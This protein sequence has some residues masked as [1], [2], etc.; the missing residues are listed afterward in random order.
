MIPKLRIPQ[1]RLLQILADGSPALTIVKM[2]EEAGFSTISATTW[3]ALNGVRRG[4]STGGP[5]PGLLEL[6]LVAKEQLEIEAGLVETVYQITKL[7][8]AVLEQQGRK[9][10]EL[11]SK[12]SSI[13]K[14][15][16][17]QSRHPT[18]QVSSLYG[19][20]TEEWSEP[21]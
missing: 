7:G 12:E 13:N 3:R 2:A 17:E 1:L 8:R 20:E 15:Y 4:S 6:G 14:R 10:P 5:R 16:S 11:R 18:A 19:E 21:W 9:L